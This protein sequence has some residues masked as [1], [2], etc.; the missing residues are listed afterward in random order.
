MLVFPM[1][2]INAKWVLR[3]KIPAV[4]REQLSR[5]RDEPLLQQLFWNRELRSE[6]QAMAFVRREFA[7]QHDPFKL[8]GM[9]AAVERIVAAL[10][11]REVIGVYGDYDVDGVTATLLLVELLQGFGADV[12]PYLPLRCEEGYGLHKNALDDLHAKGVRLLITVDCG[13]T[14]VEQAEYARTLGLD[15]IIS[16]HHHVGEVLPTAVA[17]INPKRP[18]CS[19]PEEILCAVGIAYK[20]AAALL[21][22]RASAQVGMLAAKFVDLVALGTVADLVPLH[23]E[24]RAMVYAGLNQL[25]AKPRPGVTAL[26]QVA[27]CNG[28]VSAR[29]I[30]FQLGPRLN[31]AGR[32]GSAM[33]ALRLLATQDVEEANHLAVELDERNLERRR[34]TREISERALEIALEQAGEDKP[35]I[36]LAEHEDFHVGVVGLAA[37]RICEQWQVPVLVA[38]SRDGF[39]TGSARSVA[40]FHIAEALGQCEDM[41]LKHG[42][43]A[44]AAGFS[45][46]QENWV[47]FVGRMQKIAEDQLSEK[48]LRQ[49]IMVD[50]SVCSSDLTD[51]LAEQLKYFEPYGQGNPPPL[52]IWRGA[53]ISEM[54]TVGKND[55]H[56]KLKVLTD[57]GAK[58]DTIGFWLGHRLSELPTKVDLAFSFE[59]DEWKGR[60]RKQLNLKDVRAAV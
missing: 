30:G 60:E 37:S 21:E 55:S 18:D 39:I 58:L 22:R 56:L 28:L 13:V 31:A 9:D 8:A 49:T 51:R 50:A 4:G 5:W 26:L 48:D 59:K 19:Y 41:L 35:L 3:D 57:S 40:D 16:D 46:A 12:Y 53:E 24:N 36:L 45:L 2:A 44:A 33:D 32:L 7:H 1:E 20:I 10:D 54:R 43:H 47:R 27:G 42:G 34:L 15:L 17:V 6:Q 14:A 25:N 52:F 11:A 38:Q 23:G 29:T